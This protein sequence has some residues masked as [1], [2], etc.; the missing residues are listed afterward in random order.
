MDVYT[1]AVEPI[2][3]GLE[4]GH[5]AHRAAT[6]EL[7][8]VSPKTTAAPVDSVLG[9]KGPSSDLVWQLAPAAPVIAAAL[10]RGWRLWLQRDR[11]RSLRITVKESG[12]TRT[13][14]IING[15]NVSL[16]TLEN[17]VGLAFGND[18]NDP[19]GHAGSV[20]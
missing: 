14:I 7:L 10:V 13:E 17:A 2:L 16:E 18:K 20:E 12:A 5:P 19:S 3:D 9:A 4:R 11:R 8:D 6:T 1:L 15:D